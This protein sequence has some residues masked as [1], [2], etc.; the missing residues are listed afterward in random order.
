VKPSNYR[1]LLWQLLAALDTGEFDRLS[2]E[3]VRHHARGG[4]ISKFLQDTFGAVADF[5][6]FTAENWKDIDTE[7]ASF[8]NAVDARRKFAVKNR[9]LVLRVAW[10]LQASQRNKD[11]ES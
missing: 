6:I 5:S 11:S 8:E 10:A 9:G 4:T 7:F 1:F 2:A 3:N